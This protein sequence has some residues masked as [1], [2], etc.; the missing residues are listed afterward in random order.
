MGAAGGGEDDDASG[1]VP[2]SLS[3]IEDDGDGGEI[4][5]ELLS[6]PSAASAALFRQ[7]ASAFVT[8]LARQR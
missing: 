7:H 1:T 8:L 3:A 4:D 2:E 5:L 6:A